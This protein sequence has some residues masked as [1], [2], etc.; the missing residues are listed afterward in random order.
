VAISSQLLLPEVLRVLSSLDDILAAIK[1]VPRQTV[2]VAVAE[3][4]SVLEAVKDAQL[5]DIADP[6]LVGD[7]AMI[8]ELAPQVGLSLEGVEVVDE[9]D[10]L[11][12]ATI[13]TRAVREGRAHL[14]MKGQ[15][16][17]DD[18]LRAVLDKENG[19]RTG[20]IMSHCFIL[21]FRAQN[22]LLVV[23]DGA[24]N[25]APEI[26]QKA[27]IVLNAVYLAQA[28]GIARPKVGILGAVEIV[29]PAMP[30]TLEAAALAT[31]CRRGQFPT[32]DIEGPLALD[33]AISVEA[34]QAKKIGGEIAGR[35]DILVTPDIE[36]GNM[37][38]KAY[39]FM[40]GGEVAGLLVGAAAPVVLTSR[41]D[42]AKSKMYSIAAAV[43]V[44][45]MQRTGRL[46]MGKVS[47]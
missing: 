22:R 26:T 5:R 3:S 31:M 16:H 15:L 39:S 42:T 30:A 35:C 8:R 32:C 4:A 12:A 47:F 27:Q 21:D 37:L 28:L 7:A 23:T 20:A 9:P 41:A 18:F 19:L 34:A 1:D 44:A 11:K 38:A 46:K 17:S 40:A 14:L 36:S 6:L 10:D 13:A 29:N 24:M 2:A 25:I 45:G 33:N 43:L